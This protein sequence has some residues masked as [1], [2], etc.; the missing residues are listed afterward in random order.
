[1]QHSDTCFTPF[2]ADISEYTLP[3]RFT[4]PFCYEP[5]PLSQL[6]TKELQ[7]HISRQQAWSHP[8]GLTENDAGSHGKMF[9]VLVV[10]NSR[11]ELGYLA[12]FSGLLAEKLQQPGFVPPIFDRVSSF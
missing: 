3:E 11:G 10:Q 6:A 2:Q 4:F 1:M 8:F 9:G 5:H 12:A 7:Q